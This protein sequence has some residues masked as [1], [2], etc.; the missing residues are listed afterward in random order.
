M[1]WVVTGG[2]GY[3]GSHVAQELIN[4]GFKVLVFD[5]L[6][7]G[8]ESFIPSSATFVKGSI[9]NRVDVEACMKRVSLMEL[10]FGV[11]HI[12]GV[13]LPGESMN[14][15]EKYWRINTFGTLD[16]VSAAVS[17]GAR[18]VV[19]SSSCSVYG[20][21]DGQAVTEVFPTNPESPYAMSKLQAE[22]I[23]ADIS[24]SRKV[25]VVSLRYF[26]VVGTEN[27]KVFD[28]SKANLFPAIL[29]SIA[30]TKDLV[31]HG[32]DHVTSDGTCIRDYIHVGDLARAHVLAATWMLENNPDFE[33]FNFGNGIGASVLEVVKEFEKQINKEVPHKI[34]PRRIGDPASII[35]DSKKASDV[36]GWH[37]TH[38]LAEMVSSTLV[39][40][41]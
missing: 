25:S 8:Q 18:S 35:A 7:T 4:S 27:P 34:G 39:N 3:I 15:P 14:N 2:A 12:A 22:A 11:I 40:K 9:L 37:P 24:R 31:I 10:D 38:S 36:L 33:V 30:G 17:N 26:N 21:V 28:K 1:L 20:T 5:D 29:D 16:F 6:S 32:D 13:K 41:L 19:F 23:L